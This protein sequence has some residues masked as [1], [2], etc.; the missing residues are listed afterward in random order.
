[1]SSRN[2]KL[3][4]YN[5]LLTD[6]CWDVGDFRSREM[7]HALSDMGITGAAASPRLSSRGRLGRGFELLPLPGSPIDRAKSLLKIA[8]NGS[9]DIVQE[10]FQGGDVTSNGYGLVVH[11]RVGTPLVSELHNIGKPLA[12][13]KT[14]HFLPASL[15]RSNIILSYSSPMGYPILAAGSSRF[16]SIP[17]GYSKRILDS[18][19]GRESSIY[20][21]R[22]KT[23]H[24]M[25]FGYFG[26]LTSA[27][28][29]RLLLDVARLFENDHRFCFAFAGRGPMEREI[30]DQATLPRSNV[31][32]LGLLSRQ[33]TL[34]CMSQCRG[35]FAVY[36][37][38]QSR[39]GN[40][41]KTVESIA[42]DVP[43]ITT[44]LLEI[45]SDLRDKCV[46]VAE[47]S[48]NAIA[49]A[50]RAIADSPKFS[51]LDSRVHE[52]SVERIAQR[53]LCPIYLNIAN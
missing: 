18:I 36:D 49:D 52:Y 38:Y 35:T 12:I 42:V 13:M 14:L 39:L 24:R 41:V 4:Y 20:D 22:M 31:V 25:V 17:N 3:L 2:P 29:V 30:H 28:G 48:P 43:P 46:H 37:A 45:P 53:I 8:R 7:L 11:E 19:R 27:K 5:P 47:R 32:F 9:Y 10:R 34:A 15:I 44:S 26:G 6:G 50:V 21:L 16:V 23:G 33:E 1:M 40:S 51:I